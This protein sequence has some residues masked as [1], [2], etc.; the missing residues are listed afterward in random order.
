MTDVAAAMG[1][2]QL[3]RANLF[4]AR[5]ASIAARY[6]AAFA[7]LPVQLPPHAPRG[8]V[9]SWHL[10]VVQVMPSSPVSRDEFIERLFAMNIGCSV[11]YI[12][13]HAH[14]YWRARY[15]LTPEMFPVSEEVSRR[16]VSLPLY[17]RMTDDDV[18]RVIDAVKVVL[19]R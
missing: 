1:I 3:R 11:H 19:T 16:S 7:T 18:E 2:H 10:Y 14:P 17:T 13:L 15:S 5:R 6:D 4:L 9:H 12:P 8:D